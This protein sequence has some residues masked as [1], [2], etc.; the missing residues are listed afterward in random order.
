MSATVQ[1]INEFFRNAIK[2][3]VDELKI[4]LLLS[5]RQLE[6]FD[7]FYIRKQDINFIADTLNV[8]SQVINNELKAIRKKLIKLI[9]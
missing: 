3:D 5:D 8:C 4:Q 7:R 2:K 6:V 9:D 1:K